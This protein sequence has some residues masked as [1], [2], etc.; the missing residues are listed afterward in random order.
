M[1]VPLLLVSFP[2]VLHASATINPDAAAT[3]GGALAQWLAA[4]I[5][6]EDDYDWVLP[7]AASIIIPYLA[8]ELFQAPRG[9]MSWQNPL[10]GINTRDVLGLP[11]SEWIETLF[12][13]FSLASDYCVQPRPSRRATAGWSTC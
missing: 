8:W 12:I 6:L 7:V 9:D 1:V 4:K 10:V 2:R 11:G 13:G 3:L 5:F